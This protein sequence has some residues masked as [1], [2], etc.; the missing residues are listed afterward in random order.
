LYIKDLQKKAASQGSPFLLPRGRFLQI[1]CK[2]RRETG[3]EAVVDGVLVRSSALCP[4]AVSGG[5][6][7]A[8]TVCFAS[9]ADGSK[10]SALIA[11]RRQAG[12][13]SDRPTRAAKGLPCV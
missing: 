3:C 2:S 8:L 12:G 4:G 5:A 11:S 13:S 9:T 10:T 7:H 6:R 1:P